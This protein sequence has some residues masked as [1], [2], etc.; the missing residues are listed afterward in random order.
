MLNLAD[1]AQ[2][3][4]WLAQTPKVELHCHLEG[5]LRASTLVELAQHPPRDRIGLIATNTA[6]FED[7]LLE[8]HAD[9]SSSDRDA[10]GDDRA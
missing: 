3:E 8:L 6:P 5:S 2:V 4:A 10:A 9:V 1:P 7:Q